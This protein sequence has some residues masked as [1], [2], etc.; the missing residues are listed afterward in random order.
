MAE[1][2]AEQAIDKF[3]TRQARIGVIGL[4]YAGLPLACCFAD[5]GFETIGF[6]I[7][8]RKV[9]Q[10]MLG[11]SYIGHIPGSAIQKLVAN[12]TLSASVN[13]ER[14]SGCDASIICVPTPLAPGDTPDLEYVINSAR[15]IA[16]RLHRGQLIV[17]ESTTYPGTTEELLLP[18][19]NEAG[20]EVG[21][22]YFLAFSP[23]REDPANSRFSMRT[24][25]KVVG[26]M[27]ANCL[28]VTLAAY[29]QVVERTVA[30]SSPRVA[31]AVKLL[32]NIYRCVNIAMVNE[33][34]LL[35]ER[36]SI[37]IWEVIET[38][39]TKPFGFS[40]FYPGPGLGGHCIPVDPF[41]LTWK[42]RQYGFSTRFIE[43]S[44]EINR[45]MPAHVVERLGDALNLQGKA[46]NGAEI[47]LTGVAYKRDVDDVRESPA[48]AIIRL[49]EAKHACVRYHDPHVPLLRSHHL[50]REMRG[51]ELTP[52]VVRSADAVVIVT[53][54]KNVD[55]PLILDNA[56]LVVDT[57]N[58]TAPYRRPEH[59]VVR[60]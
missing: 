54:H 23:E 21:Q 29:Q 18:I 10:I 48:L 8:A 7:D 36:M 16:A 19:L 59:L 52:E 25:P 15:E 1:T 56:K 27:T 22:D 43:L 37:D 26:G 14:L 13:F 55:Y 34:K 3:R 17:L 32:E 38:A 57:R 47:L 41:Y 31:E 2:I 49:L 44:G 46:L 6:D 50:D 12:R 42:A 51:V 35:F 11:Q 58:V 53:D 60:A 9:E 5:A 28:Q 33:L 20:L 39:S 40:T 30:V 24:I 4:G 45:A